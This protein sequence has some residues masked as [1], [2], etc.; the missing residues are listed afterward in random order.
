MKARCLPKMVRRSLAVPAF[1]FDPSMLTPAQKR[2][3]EFVAEKMTELIPTELAFVLSSY[4]ESLDASGLG[5]AAIS[6]SRL[7]DQMLNDRGL[8]SHQSGLPGR[9]GEDAGNNQIRGLPKISRID[10]HARDRWGLQFPADQRGDPGGRPEGRGGTSKEVVRHL[11]EGG[12]P[13]R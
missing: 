10:E 11:A 13:G 12:Q 9:N 7:Q 5:Q 8:T 6:Y 2:H 4:K 3:I 1:R